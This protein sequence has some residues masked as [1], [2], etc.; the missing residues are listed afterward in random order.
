MEN[1]TEHLV[2]SSMQRSGL[3]AVIVGVLMTSQDEATVETVCQIT[4]DVIKQLPV[5]DEIEIRALK[6]IEDARA[7]IKVAQLINMN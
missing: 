2:S 6:E 7:R 3:M 4:E 1:L 5:G